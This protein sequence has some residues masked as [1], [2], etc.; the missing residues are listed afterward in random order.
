VINPIIWCFKK[1]SGLIQFSSEMMHHHPD[2]ARSGKPEHECNDKHKM[3]LN[4]CNLVQDIRF[5]VGNNQSRENVDLLSKH[6]RDLV[7]R[8]PREIKRLERKNR[9]LNEKNQFGYFRLFGAYCFANG[10]LNYM[11]DSCAQMFDHQ[12]DPKVEEMLDDEIGCLIEN[13]KIS[14]RTMKMRRMAVEELN[15][16][17]KMQISKKASV[18]VFGS[19]ATGISLE[20]SDLDLAIMHPNISYYEPKST[21]SSYVLD[22]VHKNMSHSS[23]CSKIIPILGAR[24][25]ILKIQ[26]SSELDRIEA[27]LK[28]GSRVQVFKDEYLKYMSSLDPRVSKLLILVKKWSKGREIGEASNHYMNSYAHSLSVIHF[29]QNCNPPVLPMID[30]NFASQSID[31]FRTGLAIRHLNFK[32]EN[33]QS[34]SELLVSYF[35]YW[36]FSFDYANSIVSLRKNFPKHSTISSRRQKF[37]HCQQIEFCVEDPLEVH[38]NVARSLNY[39]NLLNIRAEHARAFLL[40]SNGYSLNS[41]ILP[42]RRELIKNYHKLTKSRF[43]RTL[44]Y[45]L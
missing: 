35:F 3:I 31:D 22:V 43:L 42:Q 1:L 16:I 26:F 45:L 36:A 15:N 33:S 25:P 38:Q 17:V 40:L 19:C 23:F 28:L 21:V 6:A 29:L 34:I 24:I 14:E 41:A 4:L 2:D 9:D 11:E 8:I 20:S 39:E 44:R 13:S 30:P 7:D 12:Q 27:D 32:S 37:G 5:V 18:E 10:F